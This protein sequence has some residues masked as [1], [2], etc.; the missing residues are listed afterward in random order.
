M[1]IYG[2]ETRTKQIPGP[3]VTDV[4]VRSLVN[5]CGHR[6]VLQVVGEYNRASAYVGLV[7]CHGELAHEDHRALDVIGDGTAGPRAVLDVVV[8]I[9]RKGGV[10]LEGEG[11]LRNR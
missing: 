6:T 7:V 4:P 5:Y 9:S 8:D 10:F 3:Y 1:R 2:D 11:S